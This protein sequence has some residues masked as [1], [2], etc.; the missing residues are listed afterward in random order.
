MVFV[1]RLREGDRLHHRVLR[2]DRSSAT[3]YFGFGCTRWLVVVVIVEV[4]VVVVVV[5]VVVVVVAVNVLG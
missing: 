2:L 5:L 1:F 4:V 3:R